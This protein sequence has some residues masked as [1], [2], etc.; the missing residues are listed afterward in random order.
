M[1]PSFFDSGKKQRPCGTMGTMMAGKP[2]QSSRPRILLPLVLLALA[3]PAGCRG[4]LAEP[5]L[6]RHF[7]VNDLNGVITQSDLRLD[8]KISSDGKGSIQ[9]RAK[10]PLTARL[11]EVKGIDVEDARLTYQARLRSDKIKGRAYLEMW[12]HLPGHGEFFS[13]GVMTPLTG[14][15]DWTTEEVHFFLKGGEKPD[16]VKLNVVIVGTGTL[17]IDDIRLTK[18][19]N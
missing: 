7:P 11:Y 9:I 14:T 6:L 17:W 12:C 8:K 18:T 3:S 10:K 4:D 2:S 16:Y 13:R 15:T 19:P 1:A 5:V